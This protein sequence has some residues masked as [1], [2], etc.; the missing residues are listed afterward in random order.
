M[1]DE[2]PAPNQENEWMEEKGS[3]CACV[4]P[5]LQRRDCAKD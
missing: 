4:S 1:V 2:K 3:R 5:G